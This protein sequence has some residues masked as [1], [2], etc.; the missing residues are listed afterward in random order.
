[1]QIELDYLQF[2]L[3]ADVLFATSQPYITLCLHIKFWSS[4]FAWC[5]KRRAICVLY[6]THHYPYMSLLKSSGTP[7]LSHINSDFKNKS[8]MCFMLEDT[9]PWLTSSD[10]TF[11]SPTVLASP[12][13]CEAVLTR[14]VASWGGGGGTAW[15][16]VSSRAMPLSSLDSHLKTGKIYQFCDAIES[17]FL[18]SLHCLIYPKP[19]LSLFPIMIQR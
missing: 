4:G 6:F 19:S 3:I 11:V 1:M 18:S 12:S 5:S 13:W 2:P 7:F 15:S 8:S 17:P 9:I 10:M 14:G 16:L